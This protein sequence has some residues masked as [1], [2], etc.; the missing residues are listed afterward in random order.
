MDIVVQSEE[1][2]F[3]R[4]LARLFGYCVVCE[5]YSGM[6]EAISKGAHEGATTLSNEENE[7]SGCA[8]FLKGVIVPCVFAGRH[9]SGN[10]YLNH[11]A[12]S[13]CNCIHFM[14]RESEYYVAFGGTICTV[15]E[16]LV[17]WNAASLRPMFG[18]IPQR[19]FVL[20]SAYEKPLKELIEGTKIYPE[21]VL[22]VTYF[23]TAEEV[24]DMIEKDY[25]ERVQNATL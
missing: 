1:Y 12:I 15:T 21:D 6:M 17:V 10:Q 4:S 2:E 19:I 20:R 25:N 3:G 8:G 24:L 9:S 23:D 11:T 22:L 5:G 14:L 18:G 7:G 13:D 16:L